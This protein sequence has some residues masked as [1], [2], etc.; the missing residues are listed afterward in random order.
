MLTAAR[1]ALYPHSMTTTTATVKRPATA[2]PRP[3]ATCPYRRG[4]PSGIWAPEEYAKLPRYDGDVPEQVV[5]GA[6]RVF[7]CHQQDGHVCVGWL[8]HREPTDLLAVRMALARG[9]LDPSCV[10]YATTVPLFPTGRD[11][12]AHG[13]L[14]VDHP[15][16]RAHQAMLKLLRG[17]ED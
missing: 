16:E 17:R 12:A 7:Y 9:D 3:C 11:A 13:L 8:G 10:D 2:L 14:H 5:A 1:D 15:D 4:V 6:T